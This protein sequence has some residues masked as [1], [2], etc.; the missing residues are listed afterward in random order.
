MTRV[1][2]GRAN[3]WVPLVYTGA[4]P[5]CDAVGTGELKRG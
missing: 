5:R 4:A 2:Q 1:R 3:L